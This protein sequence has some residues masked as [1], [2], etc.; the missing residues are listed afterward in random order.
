M[1]E[2]HP[3]ILITGAS[4]GIGEATA[5]EFAAQGFRVILSARRLDR[6]ETLATEIIAAGGVALPV[7]TDQAE[8]S[9]IDHLIQTSL[10]ELGQIDVL[11]NN[12]GFGRLNWLENLDPLEDIEGQ[13]R[14]N[15]L[16]VLQTTRA[17]LPHMIAQRRGHIINMASMSGFVGMPT[18]SIYS[19]SKFALRGFTEALRREVGVF[20]I[21]VCG[22]YPGG[23]ETEFSRHLGY[24]RK[25]GLTTPRRFRLSPE[26][27][28]RVVVGVVRRPRRTVIIPAPMRLVAWF[29]FVF[30]G[31]VDWLVERRFTRPERGL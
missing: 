21:H 3:V 1:P 13:I 29:N 12:A 16:G 18:Y 25:T 9:Q 31:V 23:V 14:V 28:A 4:S 17:V 7:A 11:F 27:V 22:I 10:A 6:L 15:L 2:P 30:P 24:K 5:R 26:Q 8:L 20:G 19:A